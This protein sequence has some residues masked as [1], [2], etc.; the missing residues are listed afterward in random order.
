MRRDRNKQL[1]KMI[2]FANSETEDPD[3]SLRK[4]RFF[5]EFL[6]ERFKANYSPE[7]HLAID[8]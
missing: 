5:L 2:N 6:I 4:L 8:E 3:D 7:G 1:R